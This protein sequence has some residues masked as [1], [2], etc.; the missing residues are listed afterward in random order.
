MPEDE[1]RHH[2]YEY[3]YRNWSQKLQLEKSKGWENN[4]KGQPDNYSHTGSNTDLDKLSA[5]FRVTK[6]PRFFNKEIKTSESGRDDC[7]TIEW[8]EP[9]KGKLVDMFAVNIAYTLNYPPGAAGSNAKENQAREDYHNQPIV[10]GN[11]WPQK[12]VGKEGEA[13]HY[14]KAGNI[15]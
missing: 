4:I 14:K 5:P 11:L 15:H 1:V 13:G 9:A 7:Y 10:L 6:L 2:R 12:G 8:I 3:G